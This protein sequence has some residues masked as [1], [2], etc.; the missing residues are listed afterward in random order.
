MMLAPEKHPVLV[1]LYYSGP[2]QKS[3]I[4]LEEILI[5]HVSSLIPFPHVVA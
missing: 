2:L 3:N 4:F 5:P 1:F